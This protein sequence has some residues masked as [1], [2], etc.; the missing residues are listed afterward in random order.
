MSIKWFNIRWVGQALLELLMGDVD[1]PRHGQMSRLQPAPSNKSN[2]MSGLDHREH[3]ISIPIG[4]ARLRPLKDVMNYSSNRG[5]PMARQAAER[6]WPALWA[7]FIYN[8]L[9]QPGQSKYNY[10]KI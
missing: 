10:H 3:H 4:M 6:R 9:I 7:E 5:C 2:N 1:G 8:R